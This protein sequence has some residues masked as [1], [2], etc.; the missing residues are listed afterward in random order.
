M[1][2][3]IL[4]AFGLDL[5]KLEPPLDGISLTKPD[6]RPPAKIRPP[7]KKAAKAKKKPAQVNKKRAA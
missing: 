1:A 7:R 6:D 4:E 3:T 5:S 2:P